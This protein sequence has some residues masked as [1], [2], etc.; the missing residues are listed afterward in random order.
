MDQS[1]LP[2]FA[3]SQRHDRVSARRGGLLSHRPVALS[4]LPW[5]HLPVPAVLRRAVWHADANAPDHDARAGTRNLE[6]ATGCSFERLFR[7][8]TLSL[9]EDTAPIAEDKTPGVANSQQSSEKLAS[10]DLYGAVGPWGLAGPRPPGWL[11]D[12]GPLSLEL[13]GTSAAFLVAAASPKGGT[14]RI[15]LSGTRGM[16]LQVS[17][18]PLPQDRLEI[19]AEASWS[20]RAVGQS[21]RRA[22]LSPVEHRAT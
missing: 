10:L 16:Q 2:H 13:K 9:L 19:E 22:Q 11:V 4:W 6:L 7:D 8:W 1:R 5:G 14:R 12:S 18:V 20:H 21:I 17:L 3:V 15:H